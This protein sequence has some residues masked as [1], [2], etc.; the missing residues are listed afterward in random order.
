MPTIDVHQHLWPESLVSALSL[1]R[2]P[3]RLAGNRLELHEGSFGV[4]LA[5]H[6]LEV[7]L[8]LLDRDRID[9]ALVSLQ[10]TLGCE[11]VPELIDA[12]H[13]GIVE[14]AAASGGRIL[15][16]ACGE[17]RNAFA[18]ACVSAQRLVANPGELTAERG[19]LFVHPGE[20][21]APPEGM[22]AWWTSVVDYTAQ[23]QAAYAAW[24]AHGDPKTPVV[25]AI[26]AG[27]APFQLERLRSRD[28]E[29]APGANVY[30]DTASYGRHAIELAVE[31]CGIAQ[32]LYGSDTPV[33]DSRPTL[34]ALGDLFETV[35]GKNPGRLFS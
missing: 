5:A 27:G 17:H 29:I 35:A 20:T 32:I 31:T 15:P 12:Y 1:R 23:M 25:F 26:L 21:P 34:D 14:L 3:P 19:V 8:R 18:G 9:I 22:P 30:L 13:E 16:L 4:D 6:D 2:E 28:A 33:I 10:P 24:I 11:N 7:R